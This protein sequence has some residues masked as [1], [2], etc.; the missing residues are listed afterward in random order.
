[1]CL[2]MPVI[3][4]NVFPHLELRPNFQ[5]VPFSAT[6]PA[7]FQVPLGLTPTI[8][9][10]EPWAAVPIGFTVTILFPPEPWAVV[11]K[12]TQLLLEIK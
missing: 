6:L 12:A 10:P 11:P 2:N 7:K 1:M 8:L 5:Y 9:P 3:C 4:R